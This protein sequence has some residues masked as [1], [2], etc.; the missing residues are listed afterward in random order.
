MSWCSLP[1]DKLSR[2][3]HTVS[4]VIGCVSLDFILALLPGHR[5]CVCAQW[6]AGYWQGVCVCVCVPAQTACEDVLVS[7]YP[8]PP[9]V[10]DEQNTYVI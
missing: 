7:V 6:L 5:E 1:L 2:G 4:C 9:S 8:T 3:L 10:S